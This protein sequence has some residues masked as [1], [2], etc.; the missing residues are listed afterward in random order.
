MRRR[1][2]RHKKIL[3]LRKTEVSESCDR[4]HWI[5]LCGKT[6]FRRGYGPVVENRL[7]MNKPESKETTLHCHAKQLMNNF[8]TLKFTVLK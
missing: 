2:R 4:K 1:R 5:A 3:T 6:H 8:L 7:R